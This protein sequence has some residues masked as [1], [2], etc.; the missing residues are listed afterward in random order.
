MPP[1]TSSRAGTRATQTS[2]LLKNPAKPVGSLFGLRRR[3]SNSETSNGRAVFIDSMG[4][5]V[6]EQPVPVLE[7]IPDDQ[8]VYGQH[9]GDAGFRMR[10][11]RVRPRLAFGR[12]AANQLVNFNRDEKGRF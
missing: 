5:M 10:K 9:A 6:P 4:M 8:D 3:F 11:Q 2:P 1:I 7:K 12:V